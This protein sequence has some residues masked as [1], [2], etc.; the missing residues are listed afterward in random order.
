M[1][2]L[3]LQLKRHYYCLL[4]TSLLSLCH[5][6]SEKTKAPDP[7]VLQG[8]FCAFPQKKLSDSGWEKRP[9]SGWT[10]T[11]DLL[12]AP[13]PPLIQDRTW[14]IREEL[15]RLMHENQPP[16]AA[17]TKKKQ[18]RNFSSGDTLED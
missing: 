14:S 2:S 1:K 18:V 11:T 16:A 8:T 7:K 4:K 10:S 17:P 15:E 5:S 9:L 13:D 3:S 6:V 12:P